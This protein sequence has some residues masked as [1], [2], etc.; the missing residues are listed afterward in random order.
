M[1]WLED[2]FSKKLNWELIVESGLIVVCVFSLTIMY[3]INYNGKTIFLEEEYTN[4]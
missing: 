2:L 4:V 3:Q 1:P